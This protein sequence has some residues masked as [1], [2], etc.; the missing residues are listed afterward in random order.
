MYQKA[1]HCTPISE[2]G[3]LSD[4]TFPKTDLLGFFRTLQPLKVRETRSQDGT[5]AFMPS[6]SLPGATVST[7][8]QSLV[9]ALAE[10]TVALKTTPSRRSIRRP[11]YVEIFSYQ[12]LKTL[13][14]L[15]EDR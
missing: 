3:E 10:I 11:R 15:T 13:T 12:S 1:P 14:L 5:L 9:S 4:L 6:N 7:E 8:A 2:H